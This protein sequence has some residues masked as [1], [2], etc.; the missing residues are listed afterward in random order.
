MVGTT[1]IR[2]VISCFLTETTIQNHT[3]YSSITGCNSRLV[4]L[5]VTDGPLLV[6]FLRSVCY[7]SQDSL[8]P[9]YL[10]FFVVY[11][12]HQSEYFRRLFPL[13]PGTVR[14]LS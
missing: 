12:F 2:S 8:A 6:G 4:S 11:A 9:Y 1:L 13:R 14:A 5:I 10:P 7:V 3:H